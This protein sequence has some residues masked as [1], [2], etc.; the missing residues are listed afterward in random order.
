[1]QKSEIQAGLVVYVANNPNRFGTLTGRKRETLAL[2][3]EVNWG[4][5]REYVDVNHLQVHNPEAIG[6]L[7]YEIKNHRYGTIQDLRRRMT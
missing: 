6:D 1:M 4:T 2:F 7:D 5:Q 3:A